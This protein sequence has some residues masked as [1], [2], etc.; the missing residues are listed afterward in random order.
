MHQSYNLT[1][2]PAIV[3]KRMHMLFGSLKTK[4]EKQ[5]CLEKLRL[6]AQS[7]TQHLL[8]KKGPFLH[9]TVGSQTQLV[10]HNMP[11]SENWTP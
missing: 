3:I 9:Q 2:N 1:Q 6:T 5:H 7:W 8:N 4:F 11:L 10:R